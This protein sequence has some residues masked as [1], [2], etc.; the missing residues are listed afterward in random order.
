MYDEATARE[1]LENLIGTFSGGRHA[2]AINPS[3]GRI[4][5]LY[6][7]PGACSLA[8]RIII[9][10]A[11]ID[12]SFEQVDL[13]SKTTEN[14]DDFSEINPTGCVPTLLLDDGEQVTENIA[15][16]SL[17]AD[18]HPDFGLEAHLGR[19]R[20]LEMLSF[21]STE[22]HIAFKPF[23]HSNDETGLAQASEAVAR[24]LDLI[25]GQVRELYLFGP[26]FT[27]ADAYLFAMLRWAV[28]FDIPMQPHLL[29]Y[30]ERVAERPMVRKALIEEGL[31][32]PANVRVEEPPLELGTTA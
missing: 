31:P 14:G 13:K 27:V 18:R 11:G 1:N 29:G 12:A 7:S 8:S 5:K 23:Y 30:Y 2:K 16:L 25:A 15:V 9:H 17:L 3:G 6:Y 24:R 19:T 21:L 32:I 10:E 20:L 4:M 26:H 22:L 28:A